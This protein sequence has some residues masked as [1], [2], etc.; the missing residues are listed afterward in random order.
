MLFWWCY[1]I[2]FYKSKNTRIF[3]IFV[4]KSCRRNCINCNT[5]GFEI[6]PCLKLTHTMHYVATLSSWVIISSWEVLSSVPVLLRSIFFRQKIFGGCLLPAFT[7]DICLG[8]R[9]IRSTA[10]WRFES[11]EIQIGCRNGK[12]FWRQVGCTLP[13]TGF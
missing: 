7:F 4:C 3:V 11:V 5:I 13:E 10:D 12:I 9:W 2:C 6:I 1:V 8:T